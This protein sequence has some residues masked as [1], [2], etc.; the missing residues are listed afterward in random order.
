MLYDVFFTRV[1]CIAHKGLL[2]TG[3]VGVY[4]GPMIPMREEPQAR[5]RSNNSRQFY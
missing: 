1:R 3:L 5:P 4:R 2:V